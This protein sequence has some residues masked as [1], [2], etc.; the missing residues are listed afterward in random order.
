[1]KKCPAKTRESATRLSQ[2]HSLCRG[3]PEKAKKAER[4]TT[5]VPHNDYLTLGM[6]ERDWPRARLARKMVRRRT[7]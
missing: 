4:S 6:V 7:T 2:K 3:R 1:M 5:A